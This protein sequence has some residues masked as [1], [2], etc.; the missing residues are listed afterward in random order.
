[1]EILLSIKRHKRPGTTGIAGV[2]YS[3]CATTLA[4]VF[5][6]AFSEL[7]DG[8]LSGDVIPVHLFE[9]V[10]CPI[11]KCHGA[12]T[13]ESVRDVECP[14]EDMKVLERMASRVLDEVAAPTLRERN[15]AFVSGG[16][17]S[18][19]LVSMHDAH[20]RAIS[21]DQLSFLMC[22]DCSKGYNM[23]SHTWLHR[24]LRASGLPAAMVLCITRI[25]FTQIAFLVFA[26]TVHEAV[27]FL[28]GFRQGGPLS[29]YLF[30]LVCDPFLLA[31]ASTPDV[32]LVCG[33]CDDWAAAVQ[34]I[35]AIRVIHSQHCT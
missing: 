24:V 32:M 12:N 6:E 30:V 9:T 28:A 2:A 34:S 26:G 31:L 7:Q 27:S 5:D 21:K 14:N 10:W 20:Q 11:A 25:V 3:M 15:Q 29:G 35:R 4:S 33:F 13:I 16:D 17:I 22:L 23:V 8:T 19:N 18:H 1:M